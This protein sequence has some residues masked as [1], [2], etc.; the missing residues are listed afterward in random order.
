MEKERNPPQK[1]AKA[2]REKPLLAPHKNQAWFKIFKYDFLL[3]HC[4]HSEI[5]KY[6]YTKD[7]KISTYVYIF[8]GGKTTNG[9]LIY[10]RC[11]NSLLRRHRENLLAAT[12]KI[13]KIKTY[14]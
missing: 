7:Y 10:C 14:L 13:K 11:I 1:Q 3:S 6:I 9:R 12:N 8:I 5:P 2:E 4:G